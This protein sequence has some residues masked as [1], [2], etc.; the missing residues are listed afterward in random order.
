L[1]IDTL[2]KEE[3]LA[4]R[5]FTPINGEYVPETLKS[6]S[7]TYTDLPRATDLKGRGEMNMQQDDEED[8]GIPA[9]QEFLV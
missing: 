5:G 9:K 7:C 1:L 2:R 6:S 3:W 4:V 8:E